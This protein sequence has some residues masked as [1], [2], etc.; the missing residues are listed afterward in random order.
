MNFNFEKNS[1][2]ALVCAAFFTPFTLPFGRLSVAVAL[3]LLLI[4]NIRARRFPVFSPVAWIAL[5]WIVLACIVTVNGVNPEYGVPRLQKLM[6]FIAIPVATCL[7]CNTKRLRMMM[8]AFVAGGVILSLDILI[9]N[10][11]HA[12]KSFRAEEFSSLTDAIINEGS[13]TD[14]AILALTIIA[15]LAVVFAQKSRQ[16]KLLYPVLALIVQVCAMIMNFK[17]GSWITV[18]VMVAVFIA[19]KINW[20]SLLILFAAVLLTLMLPPVQGRLAT[21][22]AEFNPD[23]GGRATMWVVIA[24]ELI[25]KHPGGIGY[26]SLTPEMMHDVFWRVEKDRDHLHSNIL[27]VLVATGWAGL[28][29]YL[30]WMCMAFWNGCRFIYLSK[31]SPEGEKTY[32]LGLTLM[33]V[34]LYINGIVEYNFGDAEIVLLYSLLMGVMAAGVRRCRLDD[35]E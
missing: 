35:L 5:V 1:Y 2:Y 25:Q 28:V 34:A 6:W 14:G 15:T 17:R 13:M 33:L 31:D 32:A 30:G 9:M 12:I 11:I 8:H 10:T 21:L 4:E 23:G 20:K 3:V 16:R 22:K 27:Q 18:L 24:P 7:M 29:L 19:I 26:K